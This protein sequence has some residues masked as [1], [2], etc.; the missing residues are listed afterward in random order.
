M[1]Q[2]PEIVPGKKLEE[3]TGLG[4]ED[5]NSVSHDRGFVEKYAE[6]QRR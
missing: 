3:T 5:K 4:L 6:E 1:D 2:S